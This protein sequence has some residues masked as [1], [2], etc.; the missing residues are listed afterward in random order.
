M[1]EI[2]EDCQP[3]GHGVKVKTTAPRTPAR[4][5]TLV[6]FV[7]HPARMRPFCGKNTR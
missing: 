6:D 4:G 5:R 2:R 1:A 7:V 3:F